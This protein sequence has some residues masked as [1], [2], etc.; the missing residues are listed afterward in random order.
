MSEDL[1]DKEKLNIDE[2][3]ITQKMAD[4][5]QDH[6]E[7]GQEAKRSNDEEC[8]KAMEEYGQEMRDEEMFRERDRE[9]LF[10]QAHF[11][12]ENERQRRRRKDGNDTENGA[13]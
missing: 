6:E 12:G 13:D 7:R 3:R 1:E 4:N 2:R 8:D 10:V 5:L 11:G 9:D